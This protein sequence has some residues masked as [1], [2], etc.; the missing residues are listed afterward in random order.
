MNL[1]PFYCIPGRTS[2]QIPLLV[3]RGAKKPREKY[4]LASFCNIIQ[5]KI[6]NQQRAGAGAEREGRARPCS[7]LCS[8][9]S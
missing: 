6:I 4:T 8:S 2:F 7:F 1:C 9:E 5:G 3:A